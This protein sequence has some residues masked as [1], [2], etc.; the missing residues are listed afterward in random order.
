[1][2]QYAN[3]MVQFSFQPDTEEESQQLD[4]LLDFK[5]TWKRLE[6]R[7]NQNCEVAPTLIA[8]LGGHETMRWIIVRRP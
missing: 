3:G 2:D 8:E 6:V 4:Q 5:H 1:V 7:K